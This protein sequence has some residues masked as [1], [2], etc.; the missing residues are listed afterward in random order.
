MPDYEEERSFNIVLE[1]EDSDGEF[2][3]YDLQTGSFAF[4]LNREFEEEGYNPHSGNSLTMGSPGHEFY[5]LNDVTT[6]DEVKVTSMTIT[7]KIAEHIDNEIMN[8]DI[9]VEE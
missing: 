9:E 1:V 3:S 2:V 4:T 8:G 7:Q 6:Q 5:E